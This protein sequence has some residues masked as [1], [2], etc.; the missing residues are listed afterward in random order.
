MRED[1]DAGKFGINGMMVKK[2]PILDKI[3]IFENVL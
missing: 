3:G 1:D 2:M